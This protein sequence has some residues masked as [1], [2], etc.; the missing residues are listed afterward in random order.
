MTLYSASTEKKPIKLLCMDSIGRVLISK[1]GRKKRSCESSGSW[2]WCVTLD[3]ELGRGT[4][5][6]RF[7]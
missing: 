4:S 5:V 2:K 7:G 6:V 1:D 3:S